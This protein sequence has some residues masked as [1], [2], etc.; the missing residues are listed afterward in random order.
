MGAA[1]QCPVAVPLPVDV[2]DPVHVTPV[3]ADSTVSVAPFVGTYWLI[4]CSVPATEAVCVTVSR[5]LP[6]SAGRDG[7]RARVLLVRVGQRQGPGHDRDR[8]GVHGGFDRTGAVGMIRPRRHDQRAL[9]GQRS[10]VDL[11]E[12][13]HGRA[14][15]EHQGGRTE[16]E[17]VVRRRGP[18]GEAQRGPDADGARRA[19]GVQRDRLGARPAHR[20]AGL[21]SQRDVAGQAAAGPLHRAPA[22]DRAGTV[23]AAAGHKGDDRAI[24]EVRIAH[25]RRRTADLKRPTPDELRG[26][27][28]VP[29]SVRQ[30]Q[31]R[32]GDERG[33]AADVLVAHARQRDRSRVG[34]RAGNDLTARVDEDRRCRRSMPT[35]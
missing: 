23:E 15:G 32:P 2:T 27:E 33:R 8:S 28:L 12:R 9:V 30:L 26:R 11:D 19:A 22:V 20:R 31:A 21:R 18:G 29:R 1:I 3:A 16:V 35:R 25:D 7:K 10:S 34:G 6:G 14:P 13:G 4:R 24:G 5:P 17:V